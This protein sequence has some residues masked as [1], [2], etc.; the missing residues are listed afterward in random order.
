MKKNTKNNNNFNKNSKYLRKIK[1]RMQFLDI[2]I[3]FVFVFIIAFFVG[4]FRF[5]ICYILFLLGHEFSHFFVA[6][7]L[8]YYPKKIKLN[9]FGAA[10]EGDD[11]FAPNDE[12][13]IIFAGPFFNF[14]FII[15][16]YL[17][18]WFNPE[19]YEFLYDILYANWAL[20]LFNILPIFPLDFGRIILLYFSKKRARNKAL[21]LIKKISVA[22]I[23]CLFCL[24]L[25][26]SFYEL[27][28]S[29]GLSAINL[30]ALA[31]SSSED[32]S[33]KRQLFVSRKFKLLKK[34]LLERVIYVDDKMKNYSLFKFIDD[35]HFVKFVFL[36]ES[37]V[38]IKTMNE[39][40]FYKQNQLL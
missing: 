30:M 1:N 27:N 9:F 31:L 6:K 40:E 37:F 22:F 25:V 2:D 39:I 36:N 10:L 19:S 29:L 18:F 11:D 5:Y 32:T 7:K 24:F 4:E 28:L 33:Y 38:V 16:C 14:C 17:S 15:F 34:G 13:K 26:S 35:N 8:G 21:I 3:S 23:I 12:I 20:F